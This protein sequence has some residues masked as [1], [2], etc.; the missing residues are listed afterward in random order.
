M[1]L[2]YWLRH[3]AEHYLLVSAQD[4]VGRRYGAPRPRRPQGPGEVFWQRLF[5]PAYRLVP[6]SLRIRVLRALPGS[7]RQQWTSWVDPPGRRDP[8]V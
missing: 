6:W 7:H 2:T 1:S 8:G 3:N 5:V 4:R